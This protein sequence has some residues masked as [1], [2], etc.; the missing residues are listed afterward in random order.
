LKKLRKDVDDR[1]EYEVAKATGADLGFDSDAP[2]EVNGDKIKK[3][4]GLKDED[5]QRFPGGYYQSQDGKTLVV[6]VRAGG[7]RRPLD[8]ATEALRRVR[9]VVQ[10]VDPKSFH[11]SIRYGLTGDLVIGLSE[12]KAI[13]DDLTEV[14]V[15]GSVLI[16][17]VV[18]LYYLQVR[19]LIAMMLTISIG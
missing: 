5:T 9:E 6:A 8:K 14:G 4:L 2:P 19:T 17:L 15:T 12:Y 1:F 7:R 16:V 18:L 3:E 13:N 11:P 10:K